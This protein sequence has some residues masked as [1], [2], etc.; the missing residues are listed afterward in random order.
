MRSKSCF[1][2]LLFGAL[3]VAQTPGVLSIVA[4]EKLTLPRAGQAVQTLH[5]HLQPG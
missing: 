1:A 2:S 4:A 5:L 3:A